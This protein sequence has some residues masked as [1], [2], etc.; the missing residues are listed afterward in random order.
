MFSFLLV[1]IISISISGVQMFVDPD[2]CA[3]DCLNTLTNVDMQQYCK[4]KA[5]KEY[6][7]VYLHT[8]LET[9][10]EVCCQ[11]LEEFDCFKT[12]GKIYCP[13]ATYEHLSTYIRE[14]SLLAMSS[15]CTDPGY[16]NWKNFCAKMVQNA[17][18]HGGEKQIDL[19]IPTATGPETKCLFDL[20][21]STDGNRIEYCKNYTKNHFH[22]TD[23]TTSV[24]CCGMYEMLFCVEKESIKY[25][26][27]SNHRLILRWSKRIKHLMSHHLCRH[28]P[29]FE[30]HHKTIDK[31]TF[32]QCQKY[33]FVLNYANPIVFNLYFLSGMIIS[34]W[35]VLVC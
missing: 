28:T 1:S 3:K 4:S 25:C 29:Y 34:L 27:R 18:N 8:P 12:E 35:K 31:Y 20:R 15:M 10:W 32:E 7:S 5:A 17:L 19:D 22:R 14:N 21:H 26:D 6:N 13:N 2:D 23:V 33:G 16:R 9:V 11:L 24:N 30:K